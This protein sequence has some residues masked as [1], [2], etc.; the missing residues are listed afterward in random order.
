MK[1]V[2]TVASAAFVAGFVIGG[3]FLRPTAPSAGRSVREKNNKDY[4]FI[5]PLL[6]CEFAD[7]KDAKLN[8]MENRARAYIAQAKSQ[9]LI[10]D[11]GFYARIGSGWTGV[12]ENGT[13]VPASLYKVPILITYL[14]L[15]EQSPELLNEKIDFTFPVTSGTQY[16]PPAEKLVWGET[17]TIDDLLS[18]MIV[19][20]DNDAESFLFRHISQKYFEDVFSDLGLPVPSAT[21]QP[22]I[23]PKQY[24]FFLRVLYNASYLGRPA[25]ERALKLLS[26]AQ[27]K[28]GVEAGLPYGTTAAHKFGEFK[29]AEQTELHD[30]GVVYAKARTYT[31][32]IMTRGKNEAELSEAIKA[33]SKIVYEEQ[34]AI[35]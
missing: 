33:I 8:G 29:D 28:D 34:S 15:A 10:T 9:G 25:S 2:A 19:Y 22:K 18:R 14:K 27:F 32:C 16:I 4:A 31:V 23:T 7:S 3:Y 20:S 24:A 17:Y 1:R 11:A 26:K 35:L 30:C 6:A 5:N 12:N 21:R 13:F